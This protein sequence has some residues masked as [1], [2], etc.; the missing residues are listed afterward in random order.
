MSGLDVTEKAY[1]KWKDI[2]AL[3]D[4]GAVGFFSYELLKFYHESGKQFG[5]DVSALHDVCAVAVLSRP[6]LFT[7]E[8]LH[9]EISCEGITRGMTCADRRLKP[10]REGNVRVVMDVDQNAFAAYVLECIGSY[11]RK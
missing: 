4:Y 7:W 6:D 9:V 5:F 11:E 2:Q 3:K 10:S 1:L 8:D